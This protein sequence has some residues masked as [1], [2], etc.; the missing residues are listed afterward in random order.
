MHWTPYVGPETVRA[1]KDGSKNRV[2][3]KRA[4]RNKMCHICC[5][6]G[7]KD[8]TPRFCVECQM[9]NFAAIQNVQALQRSISCTDFLES[10]NIVSI[11]YK[12]NGYMQIEVHKV[13][14]KKITFTLHQL[15]CWLISMPS[16][17]KNV[18]R[19]VPACDGFSNVYRPVEEHCYLLNWYCHTH[20]ICKGNIEH[21][22]SVLCFP[23]D[24]GITQELNKCTALLAEEIT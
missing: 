5:I 18:E 2:T 6:Y 24:V 14:G 12:R 4:C 11:V 8:G 10:T 17:W 19:F 1:G 21:T 7:K 23:K 9:Q 22:W 16:G 3:G 20:M 15:I 13:A